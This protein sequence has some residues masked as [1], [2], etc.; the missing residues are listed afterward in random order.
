MKKQTYITITGINYY[1]GRKPF[2]VG[3]VVKLEKE[4]DNEYDSDAIRV[5]MPFLDKIG[6]VANSAYTVSGGTLSAS[7]VYE[8][9]KKKAYAKVMFVTGNSVIAVIVDKDEAKKGKHI[10]VRKKELGYYL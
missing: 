6:Y 1:Y 8:S 4:P 9:F 10:K 5:T 7:R 3:R 2:E